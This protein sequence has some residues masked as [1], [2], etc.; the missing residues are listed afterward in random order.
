MQGHFRKGGGFT[1]PTLSILV[2]KRSKKIFKGQS[3]LGTISLGR[4]VI[5]SPKIVINLPRIY[6]K[7]L[8]KGEPYTHVDTNRQTQILLFLDKDLQKDLPY[9]IIL[10]CSIATLNVCLCVSWNCI[11]KYWFDVHTQAPHICSIDNIIL[12]ILI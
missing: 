9:S 7:L 1:H 4:V 10:F 6:K 8:Y 5:F 11:R 3:F 12:L 2:L